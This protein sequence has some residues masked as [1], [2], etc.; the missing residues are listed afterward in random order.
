MDRTGRNRGPDATFVG[1]ILR[2]QNPL[3]RFGLAA[4]IVF[5][6]LYL[7]ASAGYAR[8]ATLTAVVILVGILINRQR[9]A[10]SLGF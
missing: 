9:V 3:V 1:R 5:G 7:L 2:A 8:G 10:G 4:V 6:P